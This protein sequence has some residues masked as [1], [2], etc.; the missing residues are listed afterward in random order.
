[1]GR[2]ETGKDVRGMGSHSL[3]P[4]ETMTPTGTSD[5]NGELVSIF[6]PH[7]ISRTA[8]VATDKNTDTTASLPSLT[9]TNVPNKQKTNKGD[10]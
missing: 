6:W 5:V 8:C 2:S 10:T 7:V 1:V 4:A 3:G 9:E